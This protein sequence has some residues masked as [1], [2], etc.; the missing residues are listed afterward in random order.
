M[1]LGVIKYL[2]DISFFN[3]AIVGLSRNELQ[4]R[5][6]DGMVSIP[7]PAPLSHRRLTLKSRFGV[8]AAPGRHDGAPA[9]RHPNQWDAVP[10]N[11]RLFLVHVH[12]LLP[13]CAPL[14][15]AF[16]FLRWLSSS[17]SSPFWP[18]PSSCSTSSCG[19]GAEAR[20]ALPYERLAS[21]I[22]RAVPAFELAISQ[23]IFHSKDYNNG[24]A[25]A[26]HTY[27]KR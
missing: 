22:I 8:C 13:R 15:N 4:D 17:I 10:W 6:L 18:W 5:K 14:L 23:A 11:G 3:Y 27:M 12:L 1:T 19:S 21:F 9:A 25:L 7:C 24:R 26:G 20:A 2:Q 16:C